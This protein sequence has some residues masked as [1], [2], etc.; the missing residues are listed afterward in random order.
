MLRL[1]V[2]YLRLLYLAAGAFLCVASLLLLAGV[3]DVPVSGFFLL[4]SF[5]LYSGL[6]FLCFWLAYMLA[7]K[8]RKPYILKVMILLHSV[9]GLWMLVSLFMSMLSEGSQ[10]FGEL[11]GGLTMLALTSALPIAIAAALLRAAIKDE[12]GSCH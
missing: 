4:Y 2:N 3:A 8:R 5:L 10:W 7:K 9:L 11:F 1:A 12:G 6:T